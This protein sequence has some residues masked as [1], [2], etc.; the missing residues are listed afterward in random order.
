MQTG[1][2]KENKRGGTGSFRTTGGADLRGAGLLFGG[3]SLPRK[4]AQ[5]RFY[6][7]V[8][9]SQVSL[10]VRDGNAHA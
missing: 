8:R 4:F 2:E 10:R 6:E 3:W 5:T 7:V 1:T 9:E